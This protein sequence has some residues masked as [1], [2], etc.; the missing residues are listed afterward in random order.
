MSEARRQ[1]YVWVLAI[2]WLCV[3]GIAGV[4]AQETAPAAAPVRTSQVTSP[5]TRPPPP[6]TPPSRDLAGELRTFFAGA[7]VRFPGSPGNLE[8]EARVEKRFAASEFAAGNIRFTAPGFQPGT[9]TLILP[10]EPG[11][12]LRTVHPSLVRPGNLPEPTWA[13][14]VVYLGRGMP[15]DL[16]A[17]NGTSLRG[18]M[19]VLDFDSG[20][21]W[22]R[23]L[24]FG[25]RGFI[26]LAPEE[27]CHGDVLRKLHDTEVSFPKFYLERDAGLRL[28]AR[29]AA[30]NGVCQGRIAATPSRWQNTALRDLWVF[31]PGAA[32]DLQKDVVVFV[33]P[34]DTDGIVPELA[35]GGAAAANLHLLLALLD[36]FR[37][38]PPARSV[39]LVA[40]NAHTQGFLGERL[41]SWHLLAPG[42][43]VAAIRNMLAEDIRYDDVILQAYEKIVLNPPAPDAEQ[44]LIELRQLENHSTGKPIK[45]K[46]AVVTLA[47]R[48]VNQ[49]K[50]ELVELRHSDLAADAQEAKAAEL[51]GQLAQHVN[52][53]TLFNKVGV[54]TKLSDLSPAELDILRAYMNDILGQ[55]RQWRQLN[56][57]DLAMDSANSAVREVLGG[58]NVKLVVCLDLTWNSDQFGFCSIQSETRN[59]WSTRL[60][61]HSVR[62]A[63]ATAGAVPNPFLD[64]MTNFGGLPQAYYFPN[65]LSAIGY[66][67]IAKVPAVSLKTAFADCGP[68]FSPADTL[69]RLDN[70]VLAPTFGFVIPFLR[71]LLAEEAITTSSEL[72]AP[73]T[74]RGQWSIRVRTFKFDEMAAS[75]IPELP[76]A[77]SATVLARLNSF[78]PPVV[79]GEVVHRFFQLTD[80][81]A[82][83]TLYCLPPDGALYSAAYQMDADF[84]QVLHSIDAGDVHRKV[85]SNVTAGTETWTFA[86]FPCRE[87][88][89]PSREDSSRVAFYGITSTRYLLLDA[90]QNSAP[91]RYGMAGLS[92]VLSEK[93]MPPYSS[94]PGAFY[95]AENSAVKVLTDDKRLA[96]RAE[97]EFPEGRGFKSADEA[98]SNLFVTAAYDLGEL[99]RYRLKNMRGVSNELVNQFMGQADTARGTMEA[100]RAQQDHLAFLKSFYVFLGNEVKA[101]GGISAITND[102]LKA[103][104]FYMAL[105]LPFCFFIQKLLFRFVRLEVQLAAFAI[106]FVVTFLVFRQIHP[107]FRIAKVPEAIFI[108]FVM[109]TLGLFVIQILHAR[110]EGEMQLLFMTYSG[111]DTA[112]VGYSTVGQKAMLIGVNNMKRRRVRTTLT[113]ATIVLVTFTMLAFSSISKK[114]SPTVISVSDDAKY[115]GIFFQ[116]PG[117]L[118][119]DEAT[120]HVMR[121]L[122]AGDAEQVVVRRWLLPPPKSYGTMSYPFP[123]VTSRGTTGQLDAVLGLSVADNGFVSRMPV[124]SG[125]R[126][127][128]AD[129]AHEALVPAG[130]AQALGLNRDDVGKT[131]LGFMGHSFTLVGI[132]D[133]DEFRMMRDLSNRPI[134]PIKDIQRSGWG[135]SEEDASV[136]LDPT[137]EESGVFYAEMS[138]LLV[139]PVE[140]AREL[141]AQPFSISVRLRD[142]A[143]VWPAI[144][145]LLTAT[146]AKFYVGSRA[147]FSLT[148]GG[149]RLNPAGT[150][151]I[152]SGYK[153]SIGGL[154]RLIIPI[155]IAGTIILNTMLGAVYERKSE[156][157]V[158]NAI[159]L[160][161]THIGLFFLA[162]AFVYSVIGSVGGY[163]IGQVLTIT[164]T[165]FHLVRGINL[166]FSSLGVVYVILFTIA[167]VLLSTLYPAMVATRTAVPSGKRKW[168][169][170]PNDGNRMQIVFPFI[171][172]P[173][174]V[175]GVLAYLAEYFARFTE[176]SVGELIATP[177]DRCHDR[178]ATG[179]D[180]YRVSYIL[181]LAPF[182][183][184]VTQRIEFLAC[185]DEVVGSYR[186]HFTITRLSGQDT[187]WTSTNKPFL[188]KLRQYLMHWRNLSSD[189][190]ARFTEQAKGMFEAG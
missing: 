60:G 175:T 53:L 123:V 42:E 89:V 149:K 24:G 148:E 114:M 35:Q 16:A 5:D 129:D 22:L 165:K 81:R 135:G 146:A 167:V 15:S 133:D 159:G 18:A 178:D 144:D 150:Y 94:G 39:L 36:E 21:A 118:R 120:L 67:H 27:F 108:A 161:P 25:F 160:N 84:R 128:S 125:G 96:L 92:T 104:V 155:L 106:L 169:L 41:L 139:L 140:T 103:I 121:T 187:N 130:T 171:Y 179:R 70:A 69:A 180:R 73:A 61:V 186:V 156:I 143:P 2:G 137:A 152:G 138:A 45:L 86:L 63:Q 100:A 181:A 141:D 136:K 88:P 9:T 68:V 7:E 132:L 115:T 110:F 56:E 158:Y 109:G 40:V 102:M 116:W 65:P 145:R 62:I 13:G 52:V 50:S 14:A 79:D 177:E 127:F 172:Q 173:G 76:V 134:L 32:P 87:F 151:Y 30:A 80:V 33:A 34:L 91:R 38:R 75:L 59:A 185:Y 26:F 85:P 170:P 154:T 101:Y 112:D 23:F 71:N 78:S 12:D 163:L 113:T 48:D 174:L 49:L 51:R 66:F 29:L 124:L 1:I 131:R 107:A 43:Q 164:L 55:F 19:A 168:S 188:E 3:L 98:D 166:N 64:T 10:D 8:V 44:R 11:F 117:S 126:F 147:P 83:A 189:K 31:I 153:T 97:V 6:D 82:T 58:R 37:A 95:I 99:N 176:A 105:L 47:K 46:N 111:M 184:G 157:A 72:P 162:E 142:D 183:L 90:A 77:D 54:R 190:H 17:L 93:K 74:D 119:M 57:Q 28:K 182:D 122:F 4:Q 20:D